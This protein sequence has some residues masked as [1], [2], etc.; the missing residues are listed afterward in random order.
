M[1]TVI[2]HRVHMDR[3]MNMKVFATNIGST[4]LLE[5]AA[6]GLE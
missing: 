5:I 1:A 3:I 4:V 6:V 2:T